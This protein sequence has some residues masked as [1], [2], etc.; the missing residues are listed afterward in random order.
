MKITLLTYGSRGDVQPFLALAIGLQKAGHVVKLA[1]PHRFEDFVGAYDIPFIPLAG[2]PEVISQRLNDAGANPIRMVRAMSDYIFS[3]A[4]QVARQAFA[5]CDEADLI[6]HSFLFTTGGHSLARRLGIPDVSVQTF[7]IFAPTRAF[8]PVSMPELL[9]GSLSYFFHWL[10]TQIFWHGGNI[11]FRRL[12]K[13]DPE[14]FDLDLHWPFSADDDRPRTPLVLACS[15]T[16]IPRPNDWSASHIHIP[17]YFFLDTSETYQPPAAL[18]GFLAGGEPP[19]CVTFGSMIHRDVQRIYRAVLDAIDQT[20]N[21]A[22]ILIGWGGLQD[23]HLPENVHVAE[24]VPHDWLFP[25]CKV[26]IHHG[27]AGTTAAGLRAGIPNIVVSFAADQPF[28]GKCVHAIGTGPSPIPVKKLT[29]NRLSAA[30]VEANGD[31][32]RNGAQAAGRTIRMEAG[33]GQTVKFIEEYVAKWREPPHP[34][35]FKVKLSDKYTG[36]S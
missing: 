14:T 23:R 32:I 7:P 11:G 31:A 8:P 19:I 30:L 33:V 3:I 36:F 34:Q 27:G 20:G 25:R 18:A 10:T 13:A 15:P 2:D 5:A 6:I 17:G 28:W 24:A 29:A 16:I 26:V 12:K 1:A 9:P 4:D 21:R 22:V 35:Y